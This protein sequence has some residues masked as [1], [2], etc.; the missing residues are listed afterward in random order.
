MSTEQQAADQRLIAALQKIAGD[1]V[2]LFQLRYRVAEL[3]AELAE[4]KAEKEAPE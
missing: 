3:E 2:D 1:A 4:L